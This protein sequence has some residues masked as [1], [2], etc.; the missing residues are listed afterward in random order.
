MDHPPPSYSEA[1]SIP[2][3]ATSTTTCL[4]SS[5]PNTS[6]S[7]L[8]TPHPN[9]KLVISTTNP[10]APT[11]PYS[12]HLLS[13]FGIT[14][15]EWTLFTGALS[16]SII[17]TAGQKAKAV[18]AGIA[19]GILVN[20][21][22]GVVVGMGI[23]RREIRKIII[24]GME[25]Y[26]AVEEGSEGKEGMVAKV[27]GEWNRD[28]EVRGVR[29]ALVAPGVEV[30]GALVVGQ[31]EE[32]GRDGCG[33]GVCGVSERRSCARCVRRKACSGSKECGQR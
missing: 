31:E 6:I 23:W 8:S 32:V 14:P 27:L 15:A 12:P 7:K 10:F 16:S 17:L 29:L 22:L 30:E 19:T 18:S 21:W 13:S 28:L 25:G 9:E 3:T 24:R 2:P 26:E 20:P 33:K 1:L 11:F 4:S 5:I